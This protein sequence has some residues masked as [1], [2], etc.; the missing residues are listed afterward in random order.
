MAVVVTVTVVIFGGVSVVVGEPHG[1]AG[2]RTWKKGIAK[3]WSKYW[4][5]VTWQHPLP[6]FSARF[7]SIS[8]MLLSGWTFERQ[9][10]IR[11]N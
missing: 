9:N 10:R 5:V 4:Y 3:E 6:I 2:A 11:N 8:L 1:V 7:V